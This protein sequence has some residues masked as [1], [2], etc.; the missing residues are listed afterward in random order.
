MIKKLVITKKKIN[1]LV[2]SK[3]IGSGLLYKKAKHPAPL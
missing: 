2:N 3:P 1:C